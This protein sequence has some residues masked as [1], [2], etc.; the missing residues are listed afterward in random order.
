MG[1]WEAGPY[2]AGKDADKRSLL[3]YKHVNGLQV[4]DS[5]SAFLRFSDEAKSLPD[6]D[7][8]ARFRSV[9]YASNPEFGDP[10]AAL[11]R[12]APRRAWRPR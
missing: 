4:T 5:V 1:L 2:C 10:D 11:D 9:V 7:R 8:A 12:Q 6:A 3:C